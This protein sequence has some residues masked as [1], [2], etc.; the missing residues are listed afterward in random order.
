M[1]LEI[2]WVKFSLSLACQHSQMC[3]K[4]YTFLLKTHTHTHTNKKQKKLKKK[5]EQ[6]KK[7]KTKMRRKMLLW[8]VSVEN[9]MGYNDIVCKFPLCTFNLVIELGISPGCSYELTIVYCNRR[10]HSICY[11]IITHKVHT[12][13]NENERKSLRDVLFIIYSFTS[14]YS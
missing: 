9:V 2:G 11:T 10:N 7:P 12:F 5:R 8:T 1:F 14:V 13:K 3:L 6:Q 4:I